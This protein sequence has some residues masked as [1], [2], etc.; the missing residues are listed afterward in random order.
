MPW[1]SVMEDVCPCVIEHP[2]QCLSPVPSKEGD[3][4]FKKW[5]LSPLPTAHSHS[6]N[7]I[8]LIL[9]ANV[10]FQLYTWDWWNDKAWRYKGDEGKHSASDN[11]W[12]GKGSNLRMWPYHTWHGSSFFTDRHKHLGN[13][14]AL[15]IS[16][17]HLKG[18]CK[19]MVTRLWIVHFSSSG[20]HVVLN[21]V[22]IT[23]HICIN[24]RYVFATTTYSPADDSN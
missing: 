5:N 24:A 4:S 8:A 6:P 9:Q 16:L 1:G 23:I 19:G 17:K 20:F 11:L 12:W 2:W 3:E 22:K 14:D 13:Q 18:I 15:L 7:N 21:P 10:C